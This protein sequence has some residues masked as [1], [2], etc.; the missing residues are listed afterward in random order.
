[1]MPKKSF[2][3]NFIQVF[4][5]SLP[6]IDSLTYFTQNSPIS[7]ALVLKIIFILVLLIYVIKNYR[8]EMLKNLLIYSS[9]AILLALT[10][11][12]FN[13]DGDLSIEFIA[14]SKLLF[15]P[16][17]LVLLYCIKSIEDDWFDWDIIINVALIYAI[18]VLSTTFLGISSKTFNN[19]LDL[20]GSK[21]TYLAGNDVGTILGIGIAIIMVNKFTKTGLV[22]LLILLLT[23]AIMGVKTPMMMFGLTAIYL[24]VRNLVM[25]NFV[26]QSLIG[27]TLL[28]IV[29]AIYLPN[30]N[31]RKNL[32]TRAEYVYEHKSD[33]YNL[34]SKDDVY[35]DPY[36]VVNEFVLSGRL[37]LL[38]RIKKQYLQSET[39]EYIFGIGYSPY[40]RN[41]EMDFF[42]V[43]YRLGVAGFLVYLGLLIYSF[44]IHITS[45]VPNKKK[46]VIFIIFL[47]G[48]FIG[49]VLT[50][51]S[52]AIVLAI[53]VSTLDINNRRST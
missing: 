13:V 9:I 29:S 19:N 10:F 51:I 17:L 53:I 26:K 36:I 1:M 7:V 31:I 39:D 38:E 25:K 52:V 24:V 23:A 43:F 22:K 45:S 20:S 27:I 49:H 15:L 32:D 5:L 12:F 47:G 46:F 30:S 6:V 33:Y 35:T 4:I 40:L 21:G 11:L 28:I 16:V 42:D 14:I 8:G 41:T 50:A 34:E 3:I 37:G 18:I 48:F 2:I 44:K